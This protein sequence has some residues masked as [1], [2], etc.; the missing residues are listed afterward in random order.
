MEQGEIILY[1][2]D[3]IIKLE[4]HLKNETVWLS[5]EEMSQLFGRDISVIGKHIRNIFKEEE[6]VKDSV[7]AK[8]AYTAADGKTYQVDYYNLDVIISVGYRVKSKQGTRFR[9]WANQVLKEYMLKGHAINSYPHRRIE[10]KLS[11]HDRQIR[12]LADKVEFFVRTS[13]PPVEGVFFNGQIFDAYKF[14]IDLIKS[15]QQSIVLI[16]NYVDETVLLML[17]KRRTD[18]TATI[19]TQRIMPQMQLD[20][21]KHN[22]QYPPVEVKTYRD[23][24]DRFLLIDSQEVYHIGASMKDLGKKMF[25]FSRLS[26]PAP[27]I[28]NLL[29]ADEPKEEVLN[30][31]E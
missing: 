31:E 6:L 11:E 20:L 29:D 13:L 10:E 30:K 19:Y 24:H 18:V 16:D 4:V 25:A 17:S 1:Q 26:I 23:C 28:M 5:I 22:S 7:W 14:A 2:P 12:D 8:F 27:V 9:Q 15:A 21:E 3:E